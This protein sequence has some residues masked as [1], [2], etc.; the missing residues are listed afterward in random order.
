[1]SR[2]SAAVLRALL[3]GTSCLCAAGVEAGSAWAQPV[4]GQVVLGTATI[5]DHGANST[6]I[7]QKT[8]K[9]IIN[10]NSF[11]IGAGGS[12]QF[13][14]P[15][16][17]AIALN[18]VL[19]GEASSI[20]GNLSANGQVWIINQN[21]IL[22]GKGSTI[23]VGGLIATTADL[24]DSNFAAGNYSFSGSSGASVVNQ[25]TI[26]TRNGGG[27]VLSG[28]S[29]QNQGLIQADTG[30]VVLGGAQAF[31][32]DFVGDGLIKYAITQPAGNADNGQTGVT[33]SGTIAAAG[34]H[35]IMTARA[36][37]SVQ[38]AVVNNTGMI[39][40]TSAKLENGEVV[41]DGGDGD[42]ATSGS[43]DASGAGRGQS[44]GSV[45]ITGHNVTVADGAT[46]NVSGDAGGGSVRI[47]GD[48]HGQGPLQNAANTHVGHATITADATTTGNGGTLVVWS[49]GITDFSGIFS[50]R[51]GAL[52]GNGGFIETSGEHLN[53]SNDAHIDTTAPHGQTGTWL[54]DPGTIIIAAGEGT[55][56]LVDG[57]DALD[58]NPGGTDRIDAATITTALATTDVTLEASTLI[59]VD[60][61]VIYASPYAFSLMSEGNITL[62][63]S[64]QNT[65]ASG[66]GAINLVAG[67][68]GTTAPGAILST[69]GSY[70]ADDGQ[71]GRG[72]I[73]FSGAY[74]DVQVGA[75][76]GTT[77]IA[78]LDTVLTTDGGGNVQIGYHGAGGGNI[79]VVMNGGLSLFADS[80]TVVTPHYAMI[81]NGALDGSVPGQAT[82][83]IS[84][85]LVGQ[86]VLATGGC[87]CV[88]PSA[89]PR[90]IG[91]GNESGTGDPS[92]TGNVSLIFGDVD[93]GSDENGGIVPIIIN[94]LGYGDVT[95]GRLDTET[96]LELNDLGTFTSAHDL[97]LL[98]AGD[99]LVDGT[100]Q[101]DGAG[102]VTLVAGWDGIYDPSLIGHAGTYG[103]NDGTIIV[104]AGNGSPVSVGTHS[105]AL[106]LYGANLVIDGSDGDAQVGYH[107]A[108]G[109]DI[110]V[111]MTGNVTALG[112]SNSATAR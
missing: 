34:G 94:D 16:A 75:A 4:G 107:G 96:P 85:Q 62:Y 111:T 87:D 1:V 54:L 97:T 27:V 66:G 41:L 63:A 79:D 61:D 13:N 57:K 48:A 18:R 23:N 11:S 89:G 100:L 59:E 69:S 80:P 60:A 44:G 19:G 47:G 72:E 14:Q 81:G 36:A 52:S 15:N 37:S 30:T 49:N 45:A 64:I 77:T 31:T 8:G 58:N 112:G 91:I 56:S 20:Y 83:D 105:G 38:D 21:G 78:G 110:F 10:W 101:N 55:T 95:I 65:Q 2:T 26:R 28:A 53:V 68:D 88:G 102:A 99:I 70:G 43:I 108:G 90:T 76:S 12:V 24:S 84:I 32:V 50:A 39:S 103:N 73:L 82:G 7:D 104:G 74:Q 42:V 25:G 98:S 3:L 22:F 71:G 67:W 106:T 5:T 9:A 17:N 6:V 46:I 35:V 109:G 92:P 33:N 51:G 93:G 29:V 86:L 40:A